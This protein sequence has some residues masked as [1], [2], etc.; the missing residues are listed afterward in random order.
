MKT[1]SRKFYRNL[2]S[3]IS[4]AEARSEGALCLKHLRHL[5]RGDALYLYAPIFSEIDTQ[6]IFDFFSIHLKIGLPVIEG[7]EMIFYQLDSW[8]DL[9]PGKFGLEPPRRKRMRPE[10]ETMVIPGLAFSKS[11]ERLGLGKGFYDKF[12][13][14]HPK[15]FRIGLAYA[16]Q[17]SQ[18]EWELEAHDEPMDF[19]VCPSGIWGSSRK[20]KIGIEP[21]IG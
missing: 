12:L 1:E 4:Q 15:L 20:T 5:V 21:I 19:V 3:S 13:S 16:F 17:I 2:R 18:K 7:N 6:S 9:E 11:G 10:S 14:K 8:S